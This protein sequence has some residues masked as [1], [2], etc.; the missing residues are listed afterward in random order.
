[1]K[2]TT[3]TIT[4]DTNMMAI[5]H[6]AGEMWRALLVN[7]KGGMTQI[8]DSATF[9]EDAAL[10]NWLRRH[11][12]SRVTNVLPGAS[13]ICRT[14]MLPDLPA[15]Q[16]DQALHLQAEAHL[17]GL[18]P[19]HRQGMAVL[20]SAADETNRI[21][22]IAAW[23]ESVRARTPDIDVPITHAPDVAA[24]ASI[25][26]GNRPPNPILWV[27]RTN[28]SL[29]LALSHANGVSFRAVNE[30]IEN[31]EDAQQIIG[32][33]LAET[34]LNAQHTPEFVESIVN[35]AQQRLATLTDDTLLHVPAELLEMATNKLDGAHSDPKWW[36]TYGI[37]AGIL[38][39]QRTQLAPLAEMIDEMPE[40]H[41]SVID[42][43]V[44]RFSNPRVATLTVLA[45]LIVLMFGPVV[46]HG[47]RLFILD[48]RHDQLDVQMASLEHLE[49]QRDMYEELEES[50]WSTTKVL[51]DLANCTPTQI[52]IES[53]RLSGADRTITILGR[54][55]PEGNTTGP[56]FLDQMV[57]WMEASRVFRVTNHSFDNP[58]Y[59][60]IYEVT[61]DAEVR[62]AY[63]VT[64]YES[65]RDFAKW[66]YQQRK[67]G[68]TFEEAMADDAPGSA[69][70]TA[71]GPTDLTSAQVG[72]GLDEMLGSD[73]PS[74]R[75]P[76]PPRNTNRSRPR[77][78]SSGGSGGDVVG[79]GDPDKRDTEGVGVIEIPPPITEA[80]VEAM[81]VTEVR[82]ALAKIA[83]AKQSL[84]I[85]DETRER[86]NGE[87]RMLMKGLR[88][89]TQPNRG[90][91]A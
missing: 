58:N 1:M 70:S 73:R 49:D 52:K 24:I 16:L 23:P 46:T 38:L 51:A 15:D 37:A 40:E 4:T 13:V 83:K 84:N 44:H 26:D 90:G 28:H 20:D 77:G 12:V 86:V 68:V 82:E 64:P 10:E 89:K 75:D 57:E 54:A 85:D 33:T 47:L 63:K 17:L 32:Q 9:R 48:K 62:R 55:L 35:E 71:S 56:Q 30:D 21:G 25:I 22:L 74:G 27:D 3:P 61:I 42:R 76:S 66:T 59:A 18:A 43:F 50:G 79:S 45:A 29:T 41:P 80:Q 78:G 67:Y 60:G 72:E 36:S 39:A 8:I 81:S 65:E 88:E 19:P 5:T 11:A 31:R 14:C 53:I 34:A 69:G 7:T 91:E 87:F 2:T 6:Y